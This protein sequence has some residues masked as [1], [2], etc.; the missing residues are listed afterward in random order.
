M[1]QLL[2]GRLFVSFS[3]HLYLL[4]KRSP[5]LLQGCCEEMTY[6]TSH[7]HK[8]TSVIG[9]DCVL[10]QNYFLLFQ[11]LFCALLMPFVQI[12]CQTLGRQQKNNYDLWWTFLKPR[13]SQVHFH[14]CS[15][16]LEEADSI[17]IFF[18]DEVIEY[19][20]ELAADTLVEFL[21]D[22]REK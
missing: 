13:F 8:S 3:V 6:V 19:D 18:E 11:A 2:N 9:S 20:G 1:H 12:S 4:K 7:F 17:Y 21:Y 14:L 16:G 15:S 5:C 10:S 22:V